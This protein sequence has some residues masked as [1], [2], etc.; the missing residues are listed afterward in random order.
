MHGWETASEI[1]EA[2]RNGKA[3]A[4]AITEATLARIA[5]R[6]GVLNAFTAVTRE[7]ALARARAVDEARA[8]GQQLGP[9][10]GVPITVASPDSDNAQRGTV[11][12]PWSE[13]SHVSGDL[14]EATSHVPVR[15]RV[16]AFPTADQL[17]QLQRGANGAAA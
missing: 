16:R 7:R 11:T 1:A 2:V 12:A 17:D 4:L 14:L 3:S 13:V 8:K 9:L 6:N 5:E 10:A 15:Y